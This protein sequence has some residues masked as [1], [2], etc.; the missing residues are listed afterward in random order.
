[1]ISNGDGVER[2]AIFTYLERVLASTAFRQAERSAGLLRYLVERS[3]NGSGDRVKEYTVGTE[4]L[5][6]GKDFDPRTDPIVRAEASR[7]RGRLERY[8]ETDGQSDAV[9]IELPKGTYALRFH[10]RP[11]AAAAPAQAAIPEPQGPPR[12]LILG[13]TL[14]TLATL[15]AFAAGVWSARSAPVA[16][17]PLHLEVRLQADERIASDVG[18]DVVIAPD[19]SRIVFVSIDSLGATHLRVRRLDGGAVVDLRG[20]TG[21]RAPFWSPDSRWIG[22]WA[23]GQLRKIAVDG[24]SPV[25]LCAAPD[26]LGASW[27]ADGT[28]IAAI[29]V[30]SRLVRVDASKGGTPIP[31]VD[32]SADSA[33]PRWPQVLPGGRHVLYTAIAGAG[34]DEA[35]IEVASLADG[36]RSVL[37]E[38]GTFGRY[39]APHYLTYVNQGTLYALRFDPRS[40]EIRGEKSPVLEN[41][42]YSATFGYAQF[43]VSNNGVA[44]YRSAVSSGPL[45]VALVDSAGRQTP[46]LDTPGSYAWPS[47]SPDRRHLALV[48]VESGVAGLSVF[49][50]L[51]ER[52]RFAWN[53]P[54]LQGGVWTHD[55]RYL[56]SRRLSGGVAWL[57]SSGGQPRDLI[58]N[59][60]LSVPWSFGPGDRSLTFAVVDTSTMFDL[61][62]A[63]IE[64]GAALRA[65]AAT[66]IL[67]TRAIETYPAVSHDGRWLAYSSNESGVLELYVRSLADTSIK[68]PI[69]RGG[70]VPRWSKT[71]R[72]LFYMTRDHRLMAADYSATGRSFVPAKPRQWT[73][74]RFA[75][76]GVLPNYDLF[77]D[78][79]V[80]ALLPV[81]R[82]DAHATHVAMI[83]AFP[84][85]LRRKLQ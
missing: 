56:V 14:G 30:T 28:I 70:G 25:V 35:A 81:T 77:D 53:A 13:F 27:G 57:P 2:A 55:G 49:T 68:V 20:T 54:G 19:G 33:V 71:G 34:V 46:L 17:T 50:N 12:R 22:F 11:P 43:S 85:E 66:H 73:P 80:V 16:P 24:G 60:Q 64:K 84:E 69:A 44:V 9:V 78:R 62:T 67:R 82:D 72:Q 31:V 48:V 52:A 7:L 39:S 40:L 75:D 59:G 47:V 29:D 6:R 37:V 58:D 51:G 3:L 4:F 76:T 38:G 63:P 10:V 15:A 26:L 61:W 79:H 45:V 23:A 42:S 32:L 41:V 21:G 1:M 74:V 18:T 65:G 36:K 8:Y 5:G 83:M